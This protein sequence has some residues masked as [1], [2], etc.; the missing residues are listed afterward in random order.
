MNP[1]FYTLVLF[2][3]S[4]IIKGKIKMLI[5]ALAVL[6]LLSWTMEVKISLYYYMQCPYFKK[7]NFQRIE[8]RIDTE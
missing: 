6:E 8:Q 1:I 3:L 5:I 4:P 2:K 7:V